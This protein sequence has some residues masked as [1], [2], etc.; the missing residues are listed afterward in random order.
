MNS[1]LYSFRNEKVMAESF[2]ELL[3]NGEKKEIRN[4]LYKD[5]NIIEVLKCYIKWFPFQRRAFANYKVLNLLFR[6]G[7]NRAVLI[8]E[9]AYEFVSEHY[10]K[11]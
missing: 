1:K 10:I 9:R 6:Q 2:I 4:F 8:S 3:A 11:L 5:N 7:K